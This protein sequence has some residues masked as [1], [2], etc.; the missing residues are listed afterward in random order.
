MLRLLPIVLLLALVAG[1][2]CGGRHYASCGRTPMYEPNITPATFR[3]LAGGY[4]HGC[5]PT[6]AVLTTYTSTGILVERVRLFPR[7]G[8]CVGDVEVDTE[9]PGGQ[10]ETELTQCERVSLTSARSIDLAGCGEGGYAVILAYCPP[11][12]P[13]AEPTPDT[14]LY[15][16]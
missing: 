2:G 6:Q 3:C 1:T 14:R 13:H 4:R 9:P 12:A 15:A 16:C 7:H 8:R 5:R 10:E 11:D